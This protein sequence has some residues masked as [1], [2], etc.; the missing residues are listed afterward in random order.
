MTQTPDSGQN[1]C[2]RPT[3]GARDPGDRFLGGRCLPTSAVAEAAVR[4]SICEEPYIHAVRLSSCLQALGVYAGGTGSPEALKPTLG[5]RILRRSGLVS[6]CGTASSERDKRAG[7]PNSLPAARTQHAQTATPA[8]EPL[9]PVRHSAAPRAVD[10]TESS[11]APAFYP[12]AWL[13]CHRWLG[14]T[15]PRMLQR[16]RAHGASGRRASPRH[17]GCAKR[18][19]C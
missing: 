7:H 8:P 15:R 2:G 4:R 3:S 5:P 6:A 19:C 1:V 13:G 16:R 18:G 10:A 17:R 14:G 12:A 9:P 11:P